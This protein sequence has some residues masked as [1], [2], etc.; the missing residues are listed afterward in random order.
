MRREDDEMTWVVYCYQIA[1]IKINLR[2]KITT[3][4][5]KRFNFKIFFSSFWLV[6]IVNLNQLMVVIMDF[7]KFMMTFRFVPMFVCTVN[8]GTKSLGKIY[9]NKSP[10]KGFALTLISYKSQK[11]KVKRPLLTQLTKKTIKLESKFSNFQIGF[12]DGT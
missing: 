4:T 1:S 2:N 10:I 5:T 11:Q 3:T 12:F 6:K 7:L 9:C 8:P